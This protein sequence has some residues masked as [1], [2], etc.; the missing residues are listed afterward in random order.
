MLT[1]TDSDPTSPQIVA[2][3]G[4][5]TAPAVS[6]STASLS[7]GGQLVGTSSTAQTVALTNTGDGVLTISSVAATGDFSA[8]K[9]C[10]QS[11]E[12]QG[13]CRISVA[14]K[15]TQTGVRTGTLSITDSDPTSPQIVTLTGTGTAPAVSLST[16][17]LSFA[18]QLVGTSSTSQTVTLTNTGDGPLTVSSITASGDFTSTPG[19]CSGTVAAGAT[20]EIGVVFKPQASG[21]RSGSLSIADDA[22]NSPQSVTLSGSGQDFAVSA[23]TTSATVTAGQTA[24]Y[25]LSLASQG[26]F[27]GPVSLTCTGTPTAA[28]C[29]LSPGSVTLTASATT[30]VT[31]RV[32]TTARSMAPPARPL[33]LL[34]PQVLL[35]LAALVLV[36]LVLTVTRAGSALPGRTR[37]WTPLGAMLLL[38]VLWTACGGGGGMP[39]PPPVTGTPAGTFTLTVAATG[40][41]LTSNVSLTLVVN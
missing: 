15:P 35:L 38:I 28:T 21:N 39:G 30:P 6:L 3:I 17:S 11:I 23:A 1:I 10:P 26:G 19:K 13:S 41:G 4:T 31:V 34:S 14:F 27:T 12:P 16:T 2:L 29:S 8:F 5:G 9:L 36:L 32:A 25:T 24:T 18:G 40:S 7:F 37:L 20:C 22:A 33:G